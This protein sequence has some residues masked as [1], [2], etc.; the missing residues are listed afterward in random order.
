[1]TTVPNFSRN[2][3][4]F[5]SWFAKLKEQRTQVVLSGGVFDLFHFGHAQYL[6]RAEAFGS[7]HIVAVNSDLS[8]EYIRGRKPIIPE[9]E[10]AGIVASLKCVSSVILFD[11]STP[12][13][14]IEALR[15][16]VFA[17]GEEYAGNE[18]PERKVMTKHGGRVVLIHQYPQRSSLIIDS[19]LKRNMRSEKF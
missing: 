13:R 7:V 5:E 19:I 18:I 14:L 3:D 11:E 17:K 15:P 6:R 9:E 12:C 2:P 10:R 8:V 1:M 16:A 4:L